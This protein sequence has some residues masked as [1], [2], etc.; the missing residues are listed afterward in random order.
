MS[1]RLIKGE[2][3]DAAR[4]L[5]SARARLAAAT[6]DIRLPGRFRLSEGQRTTIAALLANLVR[7]VED[8]LRA[9]IA[10]DP[11]VQGSEPLHAAL[12]SAHVAIA[13]PI[14]ER[15][16]DVPSLPLAATLIRR[17]EE[18]R[19]HKASA[20]DRDL[21][22]ELIADDKCAIAADAIAVLIARSARLDSFQEP[23]LGRCELS[24]EMQHA[25]VWKIAAAL[26]RYMI[27]YHDLP[28]ESADDV[29]A[30]AASHLLAGY[31]EGATLDALCLRLALG[32]QSDERLDDALLARSL[33]EAGLP[34][35]IAG[36]ALRT[37][38][39]MPSVWEVLSDP[40]GSGPVL[41]LRAAGIARGVAGAILLRLQQAGYDVAATQL[42]FFDTVGPAEAANL[43]RLWQTDAAYRSAIIDLDQA[44]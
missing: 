40:D 11:L 13:G 36:L 27:A 10:A 35:F 21:L 14:L 15:S 16:P 5:A 32:L 6:A 22:L 43:L 28:A 1:D 44:A 12:T 8:D 4:L 3:G 19:L 30:K 38:I 24:A 33:D 9:E 2:E 20:G 26:R 29:L 34:L 41:L 7:T 42:E 25:L 39:D 31:D 23:R 17:A 37:G 18:H